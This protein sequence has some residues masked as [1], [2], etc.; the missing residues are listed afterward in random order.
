MATRADTGVMRRGWWWLLLAVV[1]PAVVIIFALDGDWVLATLYG[2]A[3][4]AL[5]IWAFPWRGRS[6]IGHSRL[7][8]QPEDSAA[9]AVVVYWRPGCLY[10]SA[11]RRRLGRSGAA[12]TWINIWTDEEAAAFVRSANNGNETVPTVVI[13]GVAHT[14]PPADLVREALP[15]GDGTG[16]RAGT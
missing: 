10:C 6:A 11:L 16:H 2:A 13:D 8:E 7:L 4:L 14:N 9:R 3:M 15:A 1:V 12:A 5:L